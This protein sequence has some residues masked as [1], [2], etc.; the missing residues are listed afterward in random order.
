MKDDFVGEGAAR[1]LLSALHNL[2]ALLRSP[3]VGPKVVEPLLPEI[4]RR[5]TSL[6]RGSITAVSPYD[7]A[8]LPGVIAAWE[9]RLVT[10]LDAAAR[11][12]VDARTRLALEG[13]VAEVAPRIDALREA[14]DIR[15]RERAKGLPLELLLGS[16]VLETLAAPASTR[17]FGDALSVRA[18][19][20]KDAGLAVLA[21]PQSTLSLLAFALSFAARGTQTV[22]LFADIEDGHVRLIAQP[23]KL[24]PTHSFVA[25][26]PTDDA[27]TLL[28]APGGPLTRLADDTG[29]VSFSLTRGQGDFGVPSGA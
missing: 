11:H 22:G 9:A 6:A 18:L 16:L 15:V 26:L 8:V 25:P 19:A 14:L 27:A 28:F 12:H 10:A 3:R 13:A 23:T 5:V 4:R 24:P 21:V 7:T 17:P 29:A 2:H 20:E 1:E